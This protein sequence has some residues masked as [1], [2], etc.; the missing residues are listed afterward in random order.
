MEY[1]AAI[2]D[3]TIQKDIDSLE[4]VQRK[5]ARWARGQYGEVSVTALL[6]ELG[7]EEF[8]TTLSLFF[9]G[10]SFAHIP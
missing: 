8:Y 3:T 9:W 2:W 4:R 7:W 10:L 5:A 1:A 6:K